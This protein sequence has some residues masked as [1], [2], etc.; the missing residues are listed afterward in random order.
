MCRL[1]NIIVREETVFFRQSP[2]LPAVLPYFLGHS[3]SRH[4]T[5]PQKG[6]RPPVAVLSDNRLPRGPHSRATRSKKRADDKRL[7]LLMRGILD[8]ASRV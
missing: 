6:V 4:R 2:P 7:D 1:K 8:G 5:R 3:T